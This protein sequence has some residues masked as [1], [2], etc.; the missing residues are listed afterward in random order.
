[1]L[2]REVAERLTA[3]PGGK[4][5][6]RLSVAAQLWA[7][8]TPCFTVPPSAF[9]PPPKVE[10]AVVRIIFRAAP[11]VPLQDEAAFSRIVKAAF[12]HRRKNLVNALR[13][14][15]G[16]TVPAVRGLLDAAE[17]EP[18]RRGESLSLDDFA[19]L[20]H[21]FLQMAEERVLRY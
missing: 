3:A 18:V 1:M 7:D 17:I 14:G 21:F 5:Y 6:G 12:G 8:L 19:R 13:G 4:A 20:T 9:A 15:L 2:Q 10:S 16:L 11:R